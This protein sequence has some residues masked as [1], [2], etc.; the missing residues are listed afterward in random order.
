MSN[1]YQLSIKAPT[2][3]M[4]FQLALCFYMLSL[5]HKLVHIQITAIALKPHPPLFTVTSGQSDFRTEMSM[6]YICIAFGEQVLCK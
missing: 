2:C 5:S 6:I 4:D 3:D 1:I